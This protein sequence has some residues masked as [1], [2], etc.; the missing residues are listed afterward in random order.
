MVLSL[1]SE[2]E[3][4]F[5]RLWPICRSLT[6]D[7][8]RETLHILRELV[9]LTVHEVPSGRQVFD[10][11]IPHEWNIRDAWIE[12][13]DGR[14]VAEFSRH[15]LHVMSYSIPV[16]RYLT[17]DEL[18]PHLFSLPDMPDAIPYMTSY[19]R[20]NW[21]FCLT[22]H[23]LE[24]LPQA[25][26]YR[27]VIDST[28]APGHLTYGDL[29]LPGETAE[30][31]LF[32]TYICHPSMANNELSGP[33]VT[34]FLYR[35]VAAMPR[36][37]YTYRFVFAPETVGIVNYLFDNGTHMKRHTR[38]GYVV[39]CVGDAAPFTYKRSKH[40]TSAADL[41]AAHVLKH[42]AEPYRQIEFAVGGSDER[43][44]C[45]PGFN[46]PVGSLIRSMYLNFP[47]YHTSL[48]NK[49][50]ISFEAMVRTIGVYADIVRTLELNR[51]YVN[52]QP[53]GEPQLGKR[54]LYYTVGGNPQRR[55]DIT[56]ILHLLS[57]ADGTRD[58]IE[59]ADWRGDAALDYAGVIESL[60]SH[61]LLQALDEP[62]PVYA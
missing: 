24:S 51:Y 3:S 6:G 26:M 36:R 10:W 46:L 54:G 13:P 43:Q 25:G 33:L 53:Y 11:T 19:Y 45:S 7:G 21:G 58:L 2:L 1:P 57:F 22:H 15:N 48:D 55:E 5:D 50:F 44:Y 9:P 49:D 27:V 37:R 60:T 40:Q 20:E 56:R 18:R 61:G 38:A 59:I 14:R 52:T 28:L 39:T 23:E 41:A 34:A 17:W 30:E 29:I 32:S 35:M 4:Y 16:D 8:V 31:V 42:Q 47:E 12:T 62:Q